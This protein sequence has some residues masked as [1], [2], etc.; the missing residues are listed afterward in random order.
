[1][2]DPNQL[3]KE[4]IAQQIAALCMQGISDVDIA[5]MLN[6]TRYRVQTTKKSAEFKEIVVALGEEAARIALNAFKSKLESLE[7]LAY[8]ALRQNLIEGKLDAVKVWGEFVGLKD[9]Q[10]AKTGDTSLTVIMP[11]APVAQQPKDIEVEVE[12]ADVQSEES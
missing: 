5:K 11:G 9:K 6:V 3:V 12:D 4:S 1:M 8:Q 2:S 7:P 10:E